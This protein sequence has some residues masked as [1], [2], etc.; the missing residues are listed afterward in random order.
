MP[1]SLTLLSTP[2][3]N[4][5]ELIDTGRGRKLERFGNYQFIRPEHQAIWKPYFPES[6]WKKANAIF[7]TTDGDEMGG[8]W[9]N[10]QIINAWEMH[11]QYIKFKAQLSNSRHVGVFPEQASHWDWISVLL[12]K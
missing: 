11:Y 9:K 4:D 8:K 12:L 3:W 2:T 5:Y 7:T 6:I 1:T 10:L